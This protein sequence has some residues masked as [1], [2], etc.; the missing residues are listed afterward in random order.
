MKTQY[1]EFDALTPE[2]REQAQ[3]WLIK[4]KTEETKKALADVENT[5]ER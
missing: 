3:H 2:Q 5:H 4:R 1:R